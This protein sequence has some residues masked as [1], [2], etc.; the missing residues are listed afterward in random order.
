MSPNEVG[1]VDCEVSANE[2]EVHIKPYKL[3]RS[4]SI[5]NVYHTAKLGPIGSE[6][7]T[8]ARE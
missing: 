3:W 1:W 6:Y 7:I 4:N 2:Y 5:F 8:P